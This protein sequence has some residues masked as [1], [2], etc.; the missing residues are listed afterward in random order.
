MIAKGSS[1]TIAPPSYPMQRWRG[2]VLR[3]TPRGF[4]VQYEAFGV[5]YRETFPASALSLA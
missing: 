3:K 2:T 1:V 4:S 5:T